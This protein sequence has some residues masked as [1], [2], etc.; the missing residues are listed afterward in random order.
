MR[1]KVRAASGRRRYCGRVVQSAPLRC[2]PGFPHNSGIPLKS[3]VK[4]TE[5]NIYAKKSSG[6]MV[7]ALTLATYFVEVDIAGPLQGK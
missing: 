3:A 4:Q 2:E 6:F 1:S 7:S 5:E